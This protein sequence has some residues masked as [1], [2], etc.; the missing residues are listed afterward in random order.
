MRVIFLDIDGV[1]NSAA[2]FRYWAYVNGKTGVPECEWDQWCPV[3]TNNL[4][5][6]FAELP[7][8]VK[9][10]LSSTWRLGCKT[11]E[12]VKAIFD[13]RDVDASRVIGCTP[14][15]SSGIRGHE[16]QAWLTDYPEVTEFRIVDDDSDMA[17]LMP[18]LVKTHWN[19]GLTLS[20]VYSLVQHF[21]GTEERGTHAR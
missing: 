17:H 14:S 8:D 15:L 3:L 5:I 11:V 7:E 6:L 21:K 1:V 12:E 18:H 10:V 4:R 13:S 2:S 19:D 20:M 9:V 16:I